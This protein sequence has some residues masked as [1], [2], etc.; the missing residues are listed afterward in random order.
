MPHH[1]SN[2]LQQIDSCLEINS[3]KT[4]CINTIPNNQGKGRAL[5]LSRAECRN[6]RNHDAGILAVAIMAKDTVQS[7][8]FFISAQ[9]RISCDE[10][11]PCVGSHGTSVGILKPHHGAGELPLRAMCLNLGGQLAVQ[12]TPEPTTSTAADPTA[13]REALSVDTGRVTG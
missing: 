7:L 12:R 2:L 4:P 6:S 10:H 3:G 1:G 11:C 8:G 13:H 5:R 9:N